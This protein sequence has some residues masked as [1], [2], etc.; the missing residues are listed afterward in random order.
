MMQ[1]HALLIVPNG[2]FVQSEARVRDNEK[3][4]EGVRAFKVCRK[5]RDLD[6]QTHGL[7]TEV[8]LQ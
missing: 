6:H 8:L 4:R 2:W 1:Y 5:Q 7:P 3:E